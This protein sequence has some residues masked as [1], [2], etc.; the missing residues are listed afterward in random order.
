MSRYKRYSNPYSIDIQRYSIYGNKQQSNR[1][2]K[3]QI[4][5]EFVITIKDMDADARGVSFR[6]GY[7]IIVP[8]A[9]TGEKVRVRVT[10]INGNVIHASVIER[11]EEPKR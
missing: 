11:L 3:P 10:K 9:V 8:R 6:K 4:G 7:K 5:D 1:D 2:K